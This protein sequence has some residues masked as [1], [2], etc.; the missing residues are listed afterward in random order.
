[1]LLSNKA[2]GWLHMAILKTE[3]KICSKAFLCISYSIFEKNT[4][5]SLQSGLTVINMWAYLLAGVSQSAESPA[6]TA[7]NAIGCRELANSMR[8]VLAVANQWH[9]ADWPTPVAITKV[10]RK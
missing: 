8:G 6:S 9:T 3:H 10:F 2:K 4:S 5:L 1:M 7:P